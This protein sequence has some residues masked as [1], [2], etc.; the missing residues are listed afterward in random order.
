M[1]SANDVASH[2]G[3]GGRAPTS[4]AAPAILMV[5]D[6]E[7]FGMEVCDAL[8]QYDL[9]AELVTDWDAAIAALARF[10]PK[11][12]ILDQRLG[13]VDALSRLAQL[14]AMTTAP[15]VLLTG[16]QNEADRIIG[17]EIGADD[18]L[19]KP[20]STRELLS[21]VRAHLR[22]A[23][24]VEKPRSGWRIEPKERRLYA[25][26]G[27]VV[28]LTASEFEL[29]HCLAQS[30]GEPVSREVLDRKVLLRTSR[31]HDRSIHNLIY[32]LRR[33]IAAAGGGQ[34]IMS[35]RCRGYF[36]TGFE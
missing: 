33:K 1:L 14:R 34:V 10:Q 26:D 2:Q 16:N 25:A 21:R 18:F 3:A 7:A 23:T 17:L 4:R 5:D 13:R 8:S 6:D 27:S 15:I 28:P 32:L 31:T 30:V 19:Q 12:I 22:R 24:V 20:M 9:P 36:F 29:L 11:V 35:A